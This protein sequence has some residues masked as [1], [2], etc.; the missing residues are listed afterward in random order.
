MAWKWPWAWRPGGKNAS[1]E[2]KQAGGGFVTLYR[3]GDALWTRRDYGSLSREGFLRNPVAHRAVR[4]ISEA[5][6]AV[7]WLA[8]EGEAEL[9]AH[10]L[11][12]LLARP[13]AG[14]TGPSFMETLYG[15]LL[16]SGNAYLELV[17]AGS[18]AREMHL[19]R[20]DRVTVVA[21]GNGWPTALEHRAG[22]MKRRIQLDE[23]GAAGLHLKLF[24]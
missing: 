19:L 16:L 5:A 3:E 6:A 21:D 17:E 2:Q 24:H 23:D 15:Y 1:V 20:P 22:G 13:N 4:M 12:D 10:P 18:G 14:Q 8:Y 7:P 9:D 11:L